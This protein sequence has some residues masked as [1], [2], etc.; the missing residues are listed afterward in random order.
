MERRNDRVY[1]FFD[2]AREVS[3]FPMG[4]NCYSMRGS[5]MDTPWLRPLYLEEN[6]VH[7]ARGARSR[8]R[9][10]RCARNPDRAS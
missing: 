7:L 8:R 10:Y 5:F 4:E 6:C 3:K 1:G 9:R 2:N